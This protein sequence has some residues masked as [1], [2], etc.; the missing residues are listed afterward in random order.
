M[1]LIGAGL[2]VFASMLAAV[3]E[4]G[5]LGLFDRAPAWLIG[6]SMSVFTVVM[7]GVALWAVQFEGAQRIQSQAD[8]R[9]ER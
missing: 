9:A 7:I 8:G 2:F 6:S 3:A 1:R 4:L 5:S